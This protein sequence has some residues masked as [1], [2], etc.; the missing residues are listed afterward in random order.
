[1]KRANRILLV[2]LAAFTLLSACARPGI[3]VVPFGE[4]GSCACIYPEDAI[5][6]RF[7]SPKLAECAI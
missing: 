7:I 3:S 6:E 5:A 2:P 1:M 4:D